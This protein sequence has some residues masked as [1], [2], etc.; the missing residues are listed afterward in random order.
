M[1]ELMDVLLL[2]GCIVTSA[3]APESLSESSLLIPPPVLSV[4]GAGASA[5][6][7]A[8]GASVELST[9]QQV[10]SSSSS[11]WVRLDRPD[12]VAQTGTGPD[13]DGSGRGWMT[14]ADESV[15]FK[16]AVVFPVW[17]RPEWGV[18]NLFFGG[19]ANN[20]SVDIVASGWSSNGPNATRLTSNSTALTIHYSLACR[21]VES[22]MTMESLGPGTVRLSTT[23]TNDVSCPLTQVAYF[24]YTPLV[25]DPSRFSYLYMERVEADRN[26][27]YTLKYAR[28]GIFFYGAA[29]SSRGRMMALTAGGQY[30]TELATHPTALV[31]ATADGLV[32]ET[33]PAGFKGEV[34]HVAPLPPGQVYS[35]FCLTQ[36]NLTLF[37][38]V[39]IN[40]PMCKP[41][42]LV[43]IQKQM[44]FISI[45]L[46]PW[47][48]VFPVS[49][50]SSASYYVP[51]V[52]RTATLPDGSV[53]TTFQSRNRRWSVYNTQ[54]HLSFAFAPQ[55]AGKTA[56]AKLLLHGELSQAD[57]GTS[58]LFSTARLRC[59]KT[60]Q[61]P[62]PKKLVTSVTWAS[63]QMLFEGKSPDGESYSFL[64]TYRSLG[65]NTVPNVGS[66]CQ[67]GWIETPWTY[68]GNR[69]GKEW[70]G[71]SYGPEISGF[72]TA[73]YG[74]RGV[75]SK[76]PANAT[77]IRQ[78]LVAQSPGGDKQPSAAEVAEEAKK[79][80]DAQIFFNASGRIDFAYDGV[81]WQ[82]DVRAFC[83]VMRQNKPQ[84]IFVDDEGFGNYPSWRIH[85]ALSTNAKKRRFPG[86]SDE[87]L[88]WRMT[89]E[90]LGSWSSCLQAPE[91]KPSPPSIIFYGDGP[92]PDDIMARNGFTGSPSP[93]GPIHH[94]SM[95][96]A[97]LRIQKQQMTNDG[98]GRLFLPW[99]TAGTYGAM[100]AT[101]TLDGALHSLGVGATGFAF[102]SSSDFVDGADIL[103]LSTAT[104]VAAP[105]EDLFFTGT[106]LNSKDVL[107]QQNVLAWS[108]MTKGGISWVVVT[109]AVVGK[110]TS[111]T[112]A[113]EVLQAC[114]LIAGKVVKLKPSNTEQAGTS[115]AVFTADLDSTVVLHISKDAPAGPGCGGA[116]LGKN[117]WWPRL[118]NDEDGLSSPA[119]DRKVDS[120]LTSSGDLELE[121][122]SPVI[123]DEPSAANPKGPGVPD[124]CVGLDNS[125]FYCGG[126]FT[127]DGGIRWSQITMV[128]QPHMY[129]LLP[130]GD[131]KLQTLGSGPVAE[132]LF[133]WN[134]SYP[135]YISLDAKQTGV[136]KTPVSNPAL[137]PGRKPE[138][139]FSGIPY[140]GVNTT[141]PWNIKPGSRTYGALR[142]ANGEFLLTTCIIWNGL[143]PEQAPPHEG[144][145][146]E[147]GFTPMSIV[148]FTSKDAIHW[149]FSTVL[150][151]ATWGTPKVH[152]PPFRYNP[153]LPAE[154]WPPQIYKYWGPT[155]HDLETLSDNRTVM[156]A[157][158]MDGDSACRSASYEYFHSVFSTDF[159]R[160][161]T[162]PREIKGAGCARPRLKSLATG[163]LLMTGGRLCVENK[164]GLFLWVN[165][166]G[167]GGSE[168][169][170]TAGF[171]RHSISAAH[172][173]LW[174]GDKQYLYTN[175]VNNSALWETLAYT[176]ILPTGPDS[177][178]IMYQ[179]FLNMS[180][181]PWP[182]PSA[183]FAIQLK[184]KSKLNKLKTDDSLRVR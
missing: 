180:S 173:A 94:L 53:L 85:V 91:F 152:Y 46:P 38:G 57:S 129:N 10:G 36:T 25:S 133:G 27:S 102:F 174:R 112:F 165:E 11:P 72:T 73:G 178:A 109:P 48:H 139:W 132:T 80:T 24:G 182:G 118:K 40:F 110:M 140:P 86:E 164:T 96:P 35:G 67:P 168:A 33:L 127:Q 32:N 28:P 75:Y 84:T 122:S 162:K 9:R 92:A 66:H 130:V 101:A 103:A 93:Y 89:D 166:D 6:A 100:D 184:V 56:N 17:I 5:G 113:N 78:M 76:E 62:L 167:M 52:N 114:D 106:P 121:W 42:P 150:V 18:F 126:K 47:L 177:V 163:P 43:E 124:D 64:E 183:T 15:S 65:F 175:A 49:N 61:V 19:A 128:P 30:N 95:Y 82:Q 117:I 138:S 70:E 169:H 159:G 63:A 59:V 151:N 176:S 97:W 50:R 149:E 171:S 81:A 116:S 58:P 83:D 145:L 99:L 23:S 51:T 120:F 172:N 105:F 29:P 107:A 3:E 123:V 88:A 161:F 8:F 37:S 143:Q 144:L 60:P 148:A 34:F 68:A 160:S 22:V 45:V 119:N 154:T 98:Y 153:S 157:I 90:M 21:Q 142:M 4:V 13:G 155:E 79:W 20:R 125:H 12:G 137:G 1:M 104:A 69:T 146:P 135:S 16:G 7:P 54:V 115:G 2:L 131:G 41:T 74:H 111:I 14:V 156:A 136:E 26:F 87:Q 170:A 77:L 181:K 108:G 134:M 179:K 158:R 44:E 39:G 147:H 55:H 31:V 71:L 141:N